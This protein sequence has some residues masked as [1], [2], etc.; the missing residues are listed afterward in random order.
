MQHRRPLKRHTPKTNYRAPVIWCLVF[1]AILAVI[2]PKLIGMLMVFPLVIL[3]A[4]AIGGGMS[5]IFGGAD[6]FM[7]FFGRIFRR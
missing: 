6:I 2:T 3:G 5:L 7:A 1:L 4:A